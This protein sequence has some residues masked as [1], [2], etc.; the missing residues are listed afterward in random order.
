MVA[1]EYDR[2]ISLPFR[3]DTFEQNDTL[4]ITSL[5]DVCEL[6]Q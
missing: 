4:T 6:H 1:D 2:V 3:L 5:S